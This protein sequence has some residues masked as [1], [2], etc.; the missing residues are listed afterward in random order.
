MPVRLTP[1][2]GRDGALP[3][4]ALPCARCPG[5]QANICR[6]LPPALQADFFALAIRQRWARHEYLFRAGEPLGPVFKLTA[7]LVAVSTLLP[8]GERQILRFVRPGDVC[9]YLSDDGRYAFDGVA[10]S[11]EVVTCGFPRD[12]FDA[13]VARHGAMGAAVGAELSTVLKTVSLQMTA[14]GKLPSTARVANF[15]C[16]LQAGFAASGRPGLELDL[17]MTRTDI[18]DYLGLR[19]ETVSRAFTI[20]RRRGLIDRQ[21]DKVTILDLEGLAV[22]AHRGLTDRGP[23][24]RA[25]RPATTTPSRR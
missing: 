7:G 21:E 9:G 22:Q 11:K 24:K 17:P 14:M 10:I 5:K 16:D 4:E 23:T 8:G 19:L 13:F 18:G 2:L 15:L 25:P 6:P 20:L 1:S 3:Y 12:A